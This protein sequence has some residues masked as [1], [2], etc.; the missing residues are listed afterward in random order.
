M[1]VEMKNGTQFYV[2]KIDLCDTC[3]TLTL[4]NE[5][6]KFLRRSLSSWSQG[7]KF[8]IL[9]TTSVDG[10]RGLSFFGGINQ[11]LQRCYL[12]EFRNQSS[13]IS[14]PNDKIK[15]FASSDFL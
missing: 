6:T 15:T 7:P 14:N 11:N 2:H 13:P 9:I 5:T 12:Q 3:M 8:P 10:N 4:S 1:V